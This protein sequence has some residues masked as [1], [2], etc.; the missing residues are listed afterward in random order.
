MLK[1]KNFFFCVLGGMIV[2]PMLWVF[3]IAAYVLGSTAI[4]RELLGSFLISIYFAAKSLIHM[5]MSPEPPVPKKLGGFLA[6]YMASTITMFA[7][8]FFL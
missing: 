1:N 4:S 5:V 3:M 2:P 8:A 7:W 6:G